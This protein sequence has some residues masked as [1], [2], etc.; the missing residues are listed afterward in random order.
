MVVSA[1]PSGSYRYRGATAPQPLAATRFSWSNPHRNRN[2]RGR[3]SQRPELRANGP[4][5]SAAEG[6]SRFP[7]GM[8]K[9]GL[10]EDRFA[11]HSISVLSGGRS[12]APYG[13]V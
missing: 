4:L 9:S 3:R 1:K 10:T 13:E 7:G 11:P 8:E 5:Q 12:P 6:R 2:H